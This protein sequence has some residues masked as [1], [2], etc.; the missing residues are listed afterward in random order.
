M[1][2]AVPVPPPPVPPALDEPARERTGRGIEAGYGSRSSSSREDAEGARR[3]ERRRRAGCGEVG[4]C[5]VVVVVVVGPGGGPSGR[6]EVCEDAFVSKRSDLAAR[7]TALTMVWTCAYCNPT[8][9]VA[10]TASAAV[11]NAAA[12]PH[13]VCPTR[14]RISPRASPRPLGALSFDHS[15]RPHCTMSP[16]AAQ[17]VER[18]ASSFKD[19]SLGHSSTSAVRRIRNS[20]D[21][22]VALLW[23]FVLTLLSVRRARCA[24]SYSRGKL[25]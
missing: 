10:A 5:A 21:D 12:V 17:P 3:A 2:A 14:Q 6:G 8:I 20:V 1:P 19:H 24:Y 11:T 9:V 18:P 4:G 25:D 7:A 16:T 15:T 22:T 23:L 13:H